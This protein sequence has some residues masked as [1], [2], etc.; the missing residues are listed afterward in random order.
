MRNWYPFTLAIFFINGLGLCNDRHVHLSAE[1]AKTR[2][3]CIVLHIQIEAGAPVRDM[4]LYRSYYDLNVLERLNL[5]DYP[6]TKI[7]VRPEKKSFVVTDSM[8]SDYCDYYYYAAL[9]D[10]NGVL[11]PCNVAQVKTVDVQPPAV[12]NATTEI[13]ID[14]KNYFLEINCGGGG[15]KRYPV[16]LGR[17]PFGRKVQQD[18]LT[19]PEGKYAVGYFKPQSQFYKAIGINYP[20]PI[21]RARYARALRRGLLDAEDGEK[22][23]IGGAVQ[24]H[25]G[26]IGNNW[27]WGCVAMRNSDIEELFEPRMLKV[28]TP[29][30]IVGSEFSRDSIDAMR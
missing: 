27:T 5:S 24:I 25:G 19:T 22:P 23:S 21:D 20:T 10:E 17:N 9:H 2:A 14:K 6:I 12:G 30:W 18:C 8:V 13:L 3:H 4:T 29:I 26:G 16:S 15:V 7:V 28:G 11:L 1:T